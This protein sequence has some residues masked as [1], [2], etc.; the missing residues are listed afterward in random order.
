MLPV[1]GEVPDN[2][3]LIAEEVWDATRGTI[4]G[5]PCGASKSG[6]F[7]ELM[8]RVKHLQHYDI[9]INFYKG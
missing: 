5:W 4:R 7:Q 6:G 1:G 9:F 8:K 2:I 3:L